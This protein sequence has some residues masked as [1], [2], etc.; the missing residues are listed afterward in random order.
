MKGI[1]NINSFSNINIGN[2]LV[3][4]FRFEKYIQAILEEK[5]IQFVGNPSSFIEWKKTTNTGYDI[6][7]KLNQKQ[8][9]VECKFLKKRIYPSWFIRDWG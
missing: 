4:G 9:R 5:N 6:K 3:K 7:L 8:I 1:I 2:R